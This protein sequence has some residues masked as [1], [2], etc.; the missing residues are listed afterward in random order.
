MAV[1]SQHADKGF[2]ASKLLT[3]IKSISSQNEKSGSGVI[4]D[5][6]YTVIAPA[7][8]AK[9]G[10]LQGYLAIAWSTQKLKENIQQATIAITIALVAVIL[11]IICIL[12]LSLRFSIMKPLSQITS[13]MTVL[14]RGNMDIEIP[15][16]ASKDEI[17]EMITAIE[18]FKEAAVAKKELEEKEKESKEAQQK[19]HDDLREMIEKF[20]QEIYNILISA[21]AENDKMKNNA[22]ALSGIANTASTGANT[23][24]LASTSATEDIKAVLTATEE[25]THSISEIS[26]QSNKAQ[27]TT[28]NTAQTAKATN[29]EFNALAESVE[30][31]GEIVDMISD[32]AE[33]T[34]LLAL[35]ATIEAA[36]A[37][38]AGKGFAVVASE[39]KGLAT[40]TAKATD[41]ISQ[42]IGAVQSSAK[43]AVD[44]IA[45]ITNAIEDI[46]KVTTAIASAVEEQDTSTKN[47]INSVA[48]ATSKSENVLGD[49]E[50]VTSKI[51]DTNNEAQEVKAASK[52]MDDVVA[53]LSEGIESFLTDVYSD[54]DNRRQSHRYLINQNISV[55]I[56]GKSYKTTIID[57]NEDGGFSIKTIPGITKDMI[58]EFTYDN[59]IIEACVLRVEKDRIVV[60]QTAKKHVRAA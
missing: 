34:N 55:E 23:A 54:V 26:E 15:N 28:H 29:E 20:R 43:G 4:T 6:T 25:L 35:N 47:I 41:E 49:I 18:V 12:I 8:N 31:I 1:V 46:L 38:D 24:Y 32:I 57:K 59:E 39:V 37:G 51:N 45:S 9:S 14:A 42:Q 7:I 44:A 60:V 36:R 30:R 5:N 56:N 2:P 58:I 3:Y 16:R 22:I 50:S 10:K 27:E 13:C 52:R 53:A 40:Q 17:K 21:S 33:Q 11:L 19:R 48:D